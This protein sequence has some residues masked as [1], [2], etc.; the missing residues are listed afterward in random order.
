MKNIIAVAMLSGLSFISYAEPA[1][2][3]DIDQL[4]Q[5]MNVDSTLDS[6]YAQTRQMMVGMNKQLGIKP[7]EQALFDDHLNDVMNVMQKKMNW[8]TMKDPMSK[9]YLDNYT[10]KE[11]KDMITFYESETGRSMVKKMPKVMTQRGVQF[12]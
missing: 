12:N 5:L 8:G 2:T 3:K 7:S 4:M 6:I 11:I 10:E 9:I 1:K